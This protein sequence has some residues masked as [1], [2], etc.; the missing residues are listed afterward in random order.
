MSDVVLIFSLFPSAGEAHDCCRILLGEQLIACANRLSPA[1]SYY[2][3]EGE[4][5]TSEEHPVIF[6]TSADRADAAM[7]R[8]GELHRYQ[9]PAIVGWQADKANPLFAGWV[10]EQTGL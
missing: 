3:W 10:Q 1:V 6:K 8:L 5:D 9:A 2:R 4:T 7:A